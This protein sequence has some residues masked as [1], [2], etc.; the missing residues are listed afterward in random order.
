[1]KNII[2][3]GLSAAAVYWVANGAKMP[4]AKASGM[5][6]TDTK[7]REVIFQQNKNGYLVDQYGG[8]WA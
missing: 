6:T 5:R 1:M 4:M 8:M 2:I 3:I 7:G